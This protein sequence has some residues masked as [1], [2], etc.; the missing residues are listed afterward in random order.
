M[1]GDVFY[2][3]YEN[4][5]ISRIVDRTSINDN[6]DAHVKGAEVESTWEPI[7]GLR[8]NFAGGWEDTALAK[9][10]KSIDLID[11]TAGN[12][13]WIVVKPFITQASNCILPV[14]V[15]AAMLEA[16]QLRLARSRGIS[17]DAW[18]MPMTI[19]SIRSQDSLC[20]RSD[21]GPSTRFLPPSGYPGFDPVGSDPQRRINGGRGL[22]RTM[23][24]ASTR[25]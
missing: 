4:Y 17:G 15:V 13:D 8:F 1:N 9:G 22:R 19:M 20:A 5:Q 24:R 11:R 16:V 25:I 23:A 2:Y 14:Y 12:P 18:R 3:N 6:F 21:G 7:P 10:D